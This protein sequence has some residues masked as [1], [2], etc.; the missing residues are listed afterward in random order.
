MSPTGHF[1]PQ[2]VQRLDAGMS[3]LEEIE[4]EQRALDA[5]RLVVLD[6]I[7]EAALASD[8][9]RGSDLAHRALR[10]E[11]AT[12]LGQSEHTAER[13]LALAFLARHEY[14]GALHALA[15]GEVS[16]PHLR[17]ITAAGAIIT[18]GEPEV[19]GPRRAAYEA[20][21]LGYARE[22]AP[23]RL[24]PIAQRLAAAHAQATLA[25]RHE[26]AV[27][28]RSVRVVDADDGMADLIAHLPAEEA[29]AI[30]DRLGRI[31]RAIT[32][33]ETQVAAESAAPAPRSRDAIRA[34]VL[35]DLLLGR[36]LVEGA[37]IRA[38]IQVV[39][40][41]AALG[42]AGLD[43][44]D[45]PAGGTAA[46]QA[47]VSELIGY[48]P[49]DTGTAARLA[50]EADAWE[51]ITATPEGAVISVDRYRPSSEIRR[52]LAARDVH[53]RAPG[54]RAPISR[55]DA[56][57]TI[58]AADGGPTSTDNLAYLCRGHHTV[59]HHSDW[60]VTQGDGG[61]MTWVSPTGRIHR[62]R[63]PSRVRFQAAPR[64]GPPG[65]QDRESTPF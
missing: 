22:E 8:A 33:R 40:P 7:R 62:D 18:T 15:A 52:V 54:C 39:V 12:A 25:E 11:V 19:D 50:A 4:S 60:T 14:P 17:V 46:G 30:R 23:H 29:Y 57:H 3:R 64:E 59:K 32:D 47:G 26:Q 41:G 36:E 51:R 43:R 20:E 37:G 45:T 53:C 10:L 42:G 58:A 6:Q 65:P 28:G 27:P 38:Q 61:V 2:Q 48:G 9:A 1:T 44:V 31:A 21:V 55:C 24:R 13:S 63:P 34:D 5:R 35:C 56:D 49:I 16:L